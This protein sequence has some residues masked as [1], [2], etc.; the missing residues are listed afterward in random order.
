LPLIL[1]FGWLVGWLG[2]FPTTHHTPHLFI[3][4]THTHTHA[5][6]GLLFGLVGL[7]VGWL[8]FT[9]VGV[10]GIVVRCWVVVGVPCVG[11]VIEPSCCC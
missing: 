9:F 8:L 4:H 2:P 11:V 10:V 6:V 1:W 5:F 7:F 3:T